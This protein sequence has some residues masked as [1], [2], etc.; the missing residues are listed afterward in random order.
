MVIK[1]TAE[2]E[3]N[4]QNNRANEPLP[5]S[6]EDVTILLPTLNEADAIGSLIDEIKS[7]GYNNILVVDGFSK[8][9]TK[10]IAEEHGAR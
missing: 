4:K 5:V 10:K 9:D 1:M 3:K 8:D 2:N 7:H 6:H